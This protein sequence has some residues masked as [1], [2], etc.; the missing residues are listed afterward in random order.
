[1]I[2]DKLAD[3]TYDTVAALCAAGHSESDR[4]D[5]KF[6][7]A[8]L[9]DATKIC[10]AFANSDGG[11]IVVG[12]REDN[13][14]RTKFKVEGIDPDRELYGN[15]IRKV[16]AEPGIDIPP[17]AVIDIPGSERKLYVIEVPQSARRPHLP[18]EADKRYFYKRHGSDCVQMTLEEIRFLMNSYEEKREKLT[19]LLI[20]L[21]NIAHIL[22]DQSALPDG[23]YT[24]EIFSFEIIDRVLVE[25]Y[26][27]LKSDMPT[28]VMLNQ[29]KR[30][31]MFFNGEKTKL[32]SML[33]LSYDGGAKAAAMVLYRDQVKA[34]SPGLLSYI[35]EIEK[36]F[37]EKFG[38][39]NPYKFTIT[40]S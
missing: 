32:L 37:F 31:L 21:A 34:R 11:F 28:I 9:H 10:C 16:R 24:S 39:E 20:E 13:S 25:A 19:L 3:W 30:H 6:N 2:P 29:L 40:E 18:V 36:S 7:L 26:A 17:P 1:M 14:D 38:I 8:A 12:V 5:F 33:G 23:Y 4:H 35:H 22:R 15:F 27:F